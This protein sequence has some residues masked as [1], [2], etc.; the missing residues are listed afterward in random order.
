MGLCLPS[1]RGQVPLPC[2]TTLERRA[3]HQ[4]R[5]AACMQR[6]FL[7]LFWQRSF[8]LLPDSERAIQ[9]LRRLIWYAQP[10]PA[11]FRQAGQW[12]ERRLYPDHIV[13]KRA[14]EKCNANRPFSSLMTTRTSEIYCVSTCRTP[15]TRWRWPQTELKAAR[16]YWPARRTW[17]FATS[18]CRIWMALNFYRYC[19]AMSTLRLYR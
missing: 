10:A 3:L 13:G 6:P 18:V 14:K 7:S 9:F 16:P 5:H 12:P 8:M 2:R 11:R 4:P 19:A 17:S 15:A 1:G